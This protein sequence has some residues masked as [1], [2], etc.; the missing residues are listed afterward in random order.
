MFPHCFEESVEKMA[1]EGISSKKFM[2]SHP[3]R[4]DVVKFDDKNN[5]GMWRCEMMDIL[6]A[7]NLEDT[8]GWRRSAI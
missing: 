4:I 1:G 8:Y 5:F 2:N 6:T 3:L 7:S